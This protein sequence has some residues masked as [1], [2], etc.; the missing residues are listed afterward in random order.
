MLNTTTI[1]QLRD[2]LAPVVRYVLSVRLFSSPTLL[3][4]PIL[5]MME[6]WMTGIRATQSSLSPSNSESSR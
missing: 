2:L 3:L 6:R 4:T 5:M 1:E